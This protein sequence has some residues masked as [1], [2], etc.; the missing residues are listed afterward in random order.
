MEALELLNLIEGGESTT[1]QFKENLTNAT[2]AAQEI[3]AFAN[4]KGGKII[5]GVEDKKGEVKGLNYDDIQRINSLLST[6]AQEHI[7]SSVYIE[8]ET[9][10]VDGKKVLVVNVP[11]GTDK[12]HMDKDG[13][14]FVK[15][16]ADKRK[17]TSKME[18]KRM[19]QSSLNL[20]AEEQVVQGCSISEN[21]DFEKFKTFYFNR[22]NEA[23][24][25]QDL[26]RLLQ[27]LKLAEGENL[28]VAGLLLFGKHP[29]HFL[30][31][32]YVSAIWFAGNDKSDTT[33]KSSENFFGTLEEQYKKAYEFIRTKLNYIQTEA[34]FN[35]S[36]KPEIPFLVIEEVLVNAFLHRDYFVR[37][38]IQVFVFSDRIEIISPGKLPNS[39]TVES[40]KK[41][42]SKRRNDILCNF[43]LQLMQYRGIGSGILRVL[44]EYSNIDFVNDE[45]NEVFTVTIWRKT[46]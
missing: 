32:F 34:S 10:S 9:V 16:G 17:V 24:E 30:P 29:E 44:K 45:V 42:I 1:L 43:A 23:L 4:T 40:I 2:K 13:L 11:E 15:N 25:D 33:Y 26:S 27:N 41:G 8:T 35:A 19:L 5:I 14:I 46:T 18:L 22:Y 3:A 28:T 7:K 36:S 20:N 21:F 31:T 39:L 6:A 38:S 12:P 37:S